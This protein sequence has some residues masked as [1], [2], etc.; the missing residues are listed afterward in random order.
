MVYFPPGFTGLCNTSHFN[1]SS[2]SQSSAFVVHPRAK[3]LTRAAT[4]LD[5]YKNSVV[6]YYLVKYFVTFKRKAR[7][8]AQRRD[9]HPSNRLQPRSCRAPSAESEYAQ[10][11]RTSGR[12]GSKDTRK[13]MGITLTSKHFQEKAA[14]LQHLQ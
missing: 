2:L 7:E 12:G 11:T 10:L 3:H 9:H 6:S 4:L 14:P 5:Y 1:F 13:H 8:E